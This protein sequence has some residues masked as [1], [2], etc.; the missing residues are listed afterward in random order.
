MS[1]SEQRTRRDLA[2]HL[3]KARFAITVRHGLPAHVRE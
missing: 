3:F 1:D 2:S